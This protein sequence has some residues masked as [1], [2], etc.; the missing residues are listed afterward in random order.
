MR[1]MD[2][3]HREVSACVFRETLGEARKASLRIANA[4]TPEVIVASRPGAFY[5]SVDGRSGFAVTEHGELCGVF[6]TVRG[7]G[8]TLVKDAIFFGATHLDCFDGYLPG[9]YARHGFRETKRVPN[10]TAG[11]PDVVWMSL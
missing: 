7:R 5:L 9:L 4:T 11:Q 6:S 3:M 1:A 2:S 8:D 10:W